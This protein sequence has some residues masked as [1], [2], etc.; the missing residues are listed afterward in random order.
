M[1]KL[2]P[3]SDYQLY[4]VCVRF[5]SK[6]A[7]QVELKPV[8]P[9]VHEH[10]VLTLRIRI[11]VVNQLPEEEQNAMLH[12]LSANPGLLKYGQEH[13]RPHSK[14]IS[15][16]L[17]QLLKLHAEDE[18]MSEKMKELL[19]QSVEDFFKSVPLEE[20]L[21]GVS[22]EELLKMVP[23]EER[24]KGLSADELLKSLPPEVVT[25]LAQKLKNG[26]R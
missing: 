2:L 17:Y 4:A 7:Q 18:K 22:P 24:L 13:Y 3:V 8:S 20:R 14:Q 6:L 1:D 16:L 21:K 23:V 19:R 9:G 11:I 10:E 12:L 25:Q 15:T 26:T 5:P